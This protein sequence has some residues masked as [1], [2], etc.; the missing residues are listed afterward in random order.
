M[1]PIL[2]IKRQAELLQLNRTGVYR[3]ANT[4]QESP[5]N[6][7]LMNRIDKIHTDEPTFGYR[8]ITALMRKEGFPFNPKRI[9]RLMRKMRIYA[10]YPKPNLSKRLFAKYCKPYLLRNVTIERP[11]QV[12]GIDI[13]YLRMNGGFM[14]LF[15]IIDWYSRC[16]VD[17]E[18][19]S[20][21]EKTFVMECLERALNKGT[22]EIINSDQGSHFT[23][24][25]YLNL[26]AGK[27]VKISMDGKGRATDNART[28]R[29]FRTL[30][31]DCIY[32]QEF[33]S[34]RELRSALNAYIPKYNFQ[35]PCQA[36]DYEFPG[37]K[38]SQF[39][40]QIPA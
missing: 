24:P 13:T 9:R 30:K 36:I 40:I 20:T 16:V 29:F 22:P 4:W 11:D 32:I 19:S 39:N 10:I 25:D 28:E 31:Y 7:D 33:N 21:L 5:D 12:W 26:L 2:T 1:N 37:V 38:Y 18:L 15:I 17:F 34:P 35:R 3:K 23:N 6:L 8:I 27:G 14:Y